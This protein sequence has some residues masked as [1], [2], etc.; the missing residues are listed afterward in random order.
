ML[1]TSPKVELS[2]VT[3]GRVSATLFVHVEHDSDDVRHQLYYLSG[4][5]VLKSEECFVDSQKYTL[6]NV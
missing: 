2:D 1:C 6:I 4:D 5:Q 3:E